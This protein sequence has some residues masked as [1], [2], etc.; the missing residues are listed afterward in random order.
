MSSI[1]YWG[2]SRYW[3]V[4]LA[5]GVLMIVCGF[6]YWIWPVVGYVAA[7][8]LFGWLLIAVGVV[9]LMVSSGVNR[10]KGWGWWLAGGIIDIFIGFML[11][12]SLV[13]SE[14]ILPYFFSIVFLYWGVISIIDA[15]NLSGKK[16]W[17][18]YLINGILM[19]IAGFFFIEAGWM[20]NVMMVSFLT[21][22]AFIYWGIALCVG[23]YNF[24]PDTIGKTQP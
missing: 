11:V 6:A 23:A 22:V 10:P 3:W 4:I 8:R 9:Q 12:R 13:L 1:G 15:C 14:L 19:L 16:Y 5:V 20:Q 2:Q 21:S 7:S 17:W 18:L 24:K